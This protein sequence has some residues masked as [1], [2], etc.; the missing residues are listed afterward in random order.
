MQ[1][2]NISLTEEQTKLVD[3]MSSKH[4]FAN[5]SEFFRTLL[6]ILLYKP[7]I[8]KESDLLPFESP[9]VK[10]SDAILKSFKDSK[11][12]SKGFLKDLERGLK[13]SSY[14]DKK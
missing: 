13:E 2:V 9:A 11:K 12:Y 7:E 6:R 14:F 5:R 1:T 8:I 4:G 10:S 3:E